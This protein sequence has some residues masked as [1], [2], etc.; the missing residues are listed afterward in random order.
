M[1][2]KKIS[3][4][5]I[6]CFCGRSAGTSYDY[7]GFRFCIRIWSRS[8]FSYCS[9]MIR[10][11]N[12]PAYLRKPRA[13]MIRTNRFLMRSAG[14]EPAWSPIRPSN[15]RV[16]HFHHDRAT[17]PIIITKTRFDTRAGHYSSVQLINRYYYTFNTYRC[18]W[19]SK[20]HQYTHPFAPTP[21]PTPTPIPI[22]V[23]IPLPNPYLRLHLILHPLLY[24]HL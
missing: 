22:P 5:Y 20:R 23:P 11:P 1:K 4:F 18:Q 2:Y 8:V 14:L 3:F 15:V 6:L 7:T 10:N 17:F 9:P 13:R 19:S 21:A 12:H 24:L 16:C